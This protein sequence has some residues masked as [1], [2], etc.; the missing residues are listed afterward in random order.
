VNRSTPSVRKLTQVCLALV[1]VLALIAAPFTPSPPAHGV[2]PEASVVFSDIT[3]TSTGLTLTGTTTNTGTEPIYRAQVVLWI[4]TDPITTKDQLDGAVSSNAELDTGNRIL[5]NSAET[6]ITGGQAGFAPGESA[7]F[8]VSASWKELGIN[9]D[10]VYLGGVHVRGSSSTTSS[11][12]TI[13]RGRTLITHATELQATT[14]TVVML[15]C[16]PSLLT[17]SVFTNDSLADELDTRLATL[18]DLAKEPTMTWAVDPRLY[19][20]VRIMAG[21]YTIW[22]GLTTTPG[23]HSDLARAW[24]AEFDQLDRSLGYR[25]PWSDPDL[26]FGYTSGTDVITPAVLAGE[27]N[28]ELNDLP[29]LIR[30]HGGRVDEGFLDYMMELEPDIIL[31]STSRSATFHDT[32]VINTMADPFP[33]GPGP[34]N[35]DTNLQKIQRATAESAVSKVPQIRVIETTEQAALLSPPSWVKTVPL[36]SI[37]TQGPWSPSAWDSPPMGVLTKDVITALKTA[38]ATVKEYADLIGDD[39][40]TQ[41]LTTVPMASI[42]SQSWTSPEEA[43]A[44]AE[45]VDTWLKE[46]MGRVTIWAPAHVSLTSRTSQFPVTITNGL[47]VPVSVRVKAHVVTAADS[48]ALL[49][50]LTSD[51]VHVGPGDRLSINLSSRILREGETDAVLILE[52]P[53]GTVLESETTIHI[54]ARASAWMGWMVTGSA[55]FL[56][57]LGTFLRV[58]TAK[59]KRESS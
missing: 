27:A 38:H 18:I 40:A 8:T 20:E 24:L 34:D 35:P 23:T 14:A 39:E 56:F 2:E 19:H 3:V 32:I 29:L 17:D 1:S 10:G 30:P 37:Q 28:P 52:T 22:D 59:R 13:A 54:S 41:V 53:A 48:P 33:G 43:H 50:V 42:A 15:T 26:G 45:A 49:S 47:T 55:F 4:D 25:L 36:W 7:P 9:R 51:V 44:Y 16:P 58:R 5:L 31:A 11:P 46:I 57:M 21:G 6:I 12:V